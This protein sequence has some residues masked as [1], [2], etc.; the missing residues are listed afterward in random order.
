MITRARHPVWCAAYPILLVVIWMATCVRIFALNSSLPPGS[1]FDLGHWYLQLP[2]EN[3]MLTGTNNGVDS[4]STSQL[5]NG[6]TNAYFYTGGDGAMVF[7]CPDD[8]ATTS[9]STHPRSELRE[10]LNPGDNSVNWTP[11]GIHTMTATC[12]VSNVPS[13]TLKVCIGQI[14]ENA[15][16]GVPM[17]MIMFYNNTIYA[18][19]WPDGNNNTSS[20]WSYGSFALGSTI[21]YQMVVSNGLLSLAINGK[22]NSFN[23]FTSGANWQSAANAVYFKAG[24]YSQTTNK[25]KCS[26]DGAKVAFY[27]LSHSHTPCITNQ[28]TSHIGVTKGN[29]SFNV[30]AIGNGALSYQWWFNGTNPLPNATNASLVLTNIA[31]TNQGTYTATVADSTP[32]FS[33]ITSATATLTVKPLFLSAAISSNRNVKITLNGAPGSNYLLFAATNLSNPLWQMISTNAADTNG[34]SV[35][36]ETNL[37]LF[38]K[39][40]YRFE[41]H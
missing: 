36:L 27:A 40:F 7:W 32:D 11:Y 22:T 8:G 35:Y 21:N 41:T 6:F 28:P 4:A 5:T 39:R 26:T 12:V 31:V 1:N 24:A 17:L 38:P 3:G 13:D 19:Y 14:H 9:G 16:A 30:G 23:L 29:A 18:D 15:G 20:T 2:T 34:T 10:Q 33:P 37:T 25:C